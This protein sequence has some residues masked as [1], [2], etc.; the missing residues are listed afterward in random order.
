MTLETL[1]AERAHQQGLLGDAQHAVDVLA[2]SLPVL[3]SR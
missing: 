3:G 2:A 1:A